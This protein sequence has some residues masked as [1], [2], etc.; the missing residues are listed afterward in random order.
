MWGAEG[1]RLST[2]WK[3]KGPYISTAQHSSLVAMNWQSR[4]TARPTL[5]PTALKH[6]WSPQEEAHSAG[7]PGRT[8]PH[9]RGGGV[10]QAG[11][12]KRGQRGATGT[13]NG[14]DERKSSEISTMATR[15]GSRD[16]PREN[17]AFLR[18]RGMLEFLQFPSQWL[19][20]RTTW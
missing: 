14:G 11:G 4:Q 17:P 6:G 7:C 5:S 2:D 18:R 20:V 19:M 12:A 9:A 16:C 10:D 3:D 13:R 1:H 15:S 8:L